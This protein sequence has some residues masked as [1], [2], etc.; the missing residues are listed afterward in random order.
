MSKTV[1]FLG[2]ASAQA[3]V[4]VGL[5]RQVIVDTGLG[6]L[7]VLDGVTIGGFLCLNGSLN[8]GDLA[9]VAAARSNLGLGTA[10]LANTTAFDA[11]GSAAALVS[12]I[13]AAAS[14]ASAAQ[15]T[16][17]NAGAAAATAQTAANLGIA[18]AAAAQT[19]A[20]TGVANAATAQTTANTAVTNAAAA[21]ATATAAMPKAGGTFTGAVELGAAATAT[22]QAAT[23]SD[24]SVATTAQVH[25]AIAYDLANVTAALKNGTTATTQ[26]AADNSTK[27]STTAY[28]DAAATAAGNAAVVTAAA[29]AAALVAK[30]TPGNVTFT[31]STS[32]SHAH[33]LTGTPEPSC[34]LICNSAELNYS[35]GDKIPG[36][37]LLGHTGDFEGPG[38]TV[39][40]SATT[41]GFQVS[42]HTLYLP[43][44][45]TGDYTT[46]NAA[47]WYINP[48]ARV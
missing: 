39:W 48:V 12:S 25:A 32:Y 43:D 47:K 30:Y 28:A 38:V 24:T 23:D 2:M 34:F 10:A 5:E 35:V 31:T 13:T 7:R 29:A 33:G 18:N 22:T 11:A 36:Y 14:A 45:N 3:S 4:F 17:T 44:K 9:D 19:T 40:A 41:L 8:L 27:L 15:T 21:Q 46:I 20:N 26:A 6:S 37:L 16:A 42:S 1:Q